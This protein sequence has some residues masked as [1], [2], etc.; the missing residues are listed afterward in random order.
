MCGIA[1]FFNFGLSDLDWTDEDLMRRMLNRLSH[2]GPDEEGF[3]ISPDNRWGLGNRRLSIIDLSSGHQPI[4]NEDDTVWIV[5]NGE[6]YNYQALWQDLVE[7]G[8]L[9]K[10]NHSDT[11]VVLHLYEE[12]GVD[13][14]SQLNG[15][16]ALAIWDSRENTLWLARDRVGKKP[17]YF[18]IVN[19]VLL[20][21]SEPKSLFEC[22]QVRR[23]LE[24]DSL[25][26]YFVYR[27]VLAPRTLF[28]D[29][30]KLR[31]GHWMRCSPAGT[32]PQNCYWSVDAHPKLE[33]VMSE[34]EAAERLRELLSDAVRLRLVSDVPVAAFLSGGIDSSSIVAL[35]SQHYQGHIETYSVG[36]ADAR[37][38]ELPFARLVSEKFETTHHEIIIDVGDFAEFLPKMAYF[39]DEP[40]AD[41]SLIP[42]YYL[43][44][45][46]HDNGVKVV[47]SGEGADELFGG[48]GVYQAY[49]NRAALFRILDRLPK[50]IV[51]CLRDLPGSVHQKEMLSRVA[52]RRFVFPGAAAVWMQSELDILLT[53]ISTYNKRDDQLSVP[54]SWN[55]RGFSLD[56]MLRF[57]LMTRIPDDIL[58][59]TDRVTMA[60]SVEARTPFLDY[61]V[62]EFGMGLPG[63]MKL[64]NGVSK[65]ILKRAMSSLLPREI[66]ERSKVGFDTPIG[67]W[68]RDPLKRFVTDFVEWNEYGPRLF[69]RV[70]VSKYVEPHL[71]GKEDH[72]AKLWGLIVFQHWYDYWLGNSG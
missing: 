28:K 40:V 24:P 10:T 56:Q 6:I 52:S 2:R 15:M 25:R 38:N 66:L 36:F 26:Q 22:S 44:G 41:P 61:K 57:D 19:G 23:E 47:L 69:D 21:A 64:H 70:A 16:F 48:Y 14:L 1:G 18:T 13:C 46:V 7:R 39:L 72:A 65:Y 34:S 11:E 63:T 60:N 53:P 68:L 5:F 49:M 59:R 35:M 31:A 4:S 27:S 17:L 8:H 45:L 3:V 9:F 20:F 50:P 30:Y 55:N 54:G 33:S 62:V 12:M 29:I 67:E 43:S 71:A 42:L 37:L 32:E 51:K 58:N